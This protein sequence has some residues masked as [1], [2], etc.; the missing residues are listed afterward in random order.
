MP[1][2]RCWT[3]HTQI[4]SSGWIY[5]DEYM[6]I[7]QKNTVKI[8]KKTVLG[9]LADKLCRKNTSTL[10]SSAANNSLV[11]ASSDRKNKRLRDIGRHNLRDKRKGKGPES[12]YTPECLTGLAIPDLQALP[13]KRHQGQ[14]LPGWTQSPAP[15]NYPTVVQREILQTSDD[16]A[17]RTEATEQGNA[18]T[19]CPLCALVD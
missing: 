6:G 7:W 9:P 2:R 13:R 17:M 14:D 10:L 19:S 11:R 18:G 3:I 12:T 8:E 15:K 5:V 16:S 1:A 4:F